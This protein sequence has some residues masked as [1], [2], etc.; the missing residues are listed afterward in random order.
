[1]R[2]R[3]LLVAS[4]GR[5]WKQL[6]EISGHLNKEFDLRYATTDIRLAEQEQLEAL[7]LSDYNQNHPIKFLRGLIEAIPIIKKIKPDITFTTGAAPGLMCILASRLNGAQTMRIDS[8]AN[9]EKL[10]LSG[11][12]AS[13]FSTVT[14]TQWK[15][16]AKPDG[17]EYWGSVL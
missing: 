7:G 5:Y 16:L 4:A 11:K 1:M 15:H 2:K 14:L 12:I 10:S 3:I 8:I 17:P 9:A 13:K 6:V